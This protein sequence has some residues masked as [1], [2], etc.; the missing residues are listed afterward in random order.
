MRRTPACRLS[1]LR[2]RV[3]ESGRY[4]FS[5][6]EK[7][8]EPAEAGWFGRLG[9]DGTLPVLQAESRQVV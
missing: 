4:R 2:V 3:T 7:G 8:S 1:K 6:P 5:E 9:A